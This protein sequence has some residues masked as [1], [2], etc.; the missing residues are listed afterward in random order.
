ME[1]HYPE[2]ADPPVE[3]QSTLANDGSP[4]APPPP[5]ILRDHWS[6]AAADAEA[7]LRELR[8]AGEL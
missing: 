7:H 3:P 5:D 8:G 2:R 4:C 6:A 1:L